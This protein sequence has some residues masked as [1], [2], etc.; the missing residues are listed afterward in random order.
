MGRNKLEIKRIENNTSRQVTFCKRQ[1]GLT[2]KA[3]ELSVLCD[4]DIALIM[5]S[6]SG[7]LIPFSRKKSIEDVIARYVNLPEH[8]RGRK[9][10]QELLNRALQKLKCDTELANHLASPGNIPN[11]EQ[12]QRDINAWRLQLANAESRLR[13]LEADPQMITSLQ[14]AE[15]YERV[16]EESLT[17]VQVK[18][19][20]LEQVDMAS[21]DQPNMHDQG[22]IQMYMQT[23]NGNPSWASSS[24][25]QI[26]N[27]ISER[28]PQTSVQNFVEHGNIDGMLGI[29]DT[30]SP[31][32]FPF[33]QQG[34]GSMQFGSHASEFNTSH[35]EFE[36][37]FYE[38]S[39]SDEYIENDMTSN[40]Y[41]SAMA[42]SS[43]WESTYGSSLINPTPMVKNDYYPS[44]LGMMNSVSS[45]ISCLSDLQHLR[46]HQHEESS[47]DDGIDAPYHFNMEDAP[48][49]TTL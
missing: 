13:C 30:Q 32:I 47:Q 45:M 23:H 48:P 14:V 4:I 7:R 22:N 2:K 42:L 43:Q 26:L 6:P 39:T 17:K 37:P 49:T 24:E 21:Y 5:F 46:Q 44:G 38:G 28:D 1:N 27:W 8:E 41:G 20:Y 9:H 10:N 16:L 29:R 33:L 31:T 36:Y 15:Y 19:Q 3:Y 40:D 34:S 12:L 18:K 11:V 25:S 35:L